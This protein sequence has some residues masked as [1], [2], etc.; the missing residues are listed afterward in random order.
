[1]ISNSAQHGDYI[2]G[3]TTGWSRFDC[4]HKQ[5]YFNSPRVRTPSGARSAPSPYTKQL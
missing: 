2:A 1:M 4:T 3:W 5:R